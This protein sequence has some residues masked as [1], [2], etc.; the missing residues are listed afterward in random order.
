MWPLHT[1]LPLAHTEAP[2]A[3]SVDLAA[4]VLKLGTYGLLRITLPAGAV[5]I[6]GTIANPEVL[7][8]LAVLACFG[9]LYA[10]LVAWAQR[11]VKKLIA[12]SSVSHLGFCVLGMLAMNDEG[13][14]G[15]VYYMLTHGVSTGALFLLVGMI[16][17]RYHTRDME[18]MSGLGK[19]M[20]IWSSFFIFF[21]MA[22]VGLP[23]LNGFVSEFLT[24]LGTFQAAHLGWPFGVAAAI[25]IVLS[26][27][28]LLKASAKLVFGPLA[29]PVLTE[30]REHHGTIHPKYVMG[31]DITGREI[32]VL[33]PLAVLAVVLG[34]YPTPVLEAMQPALRSIYPSATVSAEHQAR[35]RQDR[36]NAINAQK[37]S[38]LEAQT[39][40]APASVEHG[41]PQARG[42]AGDSSDRLGL[43]MPAAA[44][45]SGAV[46]TGAAH[47]VRAEPVGAAS[48]GATSAGR[49][50]ATVDGRAGE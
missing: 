20:P 48:A 43:A 33:S 13:L 12:Y 42:G 18:E 25:G 5:N 49:S 37:P 38:A 28:Y 23:G 4:L 45:A 39:D 46:D 32:A 2:T 40:P 31:G 35:Q 3:G 30:E 8:A 15:S 21:V 9:V 14:Q 11:D 27:L 47:S 34:M 17:N 1:W 50:A 19:A 41:E 36:V 26:A 24:L 10:G 29:Y 6:N 22:S 7:Q 16:Y 44:V